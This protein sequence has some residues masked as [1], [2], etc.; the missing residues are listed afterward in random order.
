[1]A[2]KK[3]QAEKDAKG[4]SALAV[5]I[6]CSREMRCS[7][8]GLANSCVAGSGAGV[9]FPMLMPLTQ[10]PVASTEMIGD[11]EAH[12]RIPKPSGCDPSGR[13]MASLSPR[14]MLTCTISCESLVRTGSP[15][16]R[17]LNRKACGK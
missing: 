8:D 5:A 16:Y 7:A 9:F 1:M 2:P 13:T 4:A 15:Y 11:T 6:A 17:I 12:A 3:C 14:P 10:S